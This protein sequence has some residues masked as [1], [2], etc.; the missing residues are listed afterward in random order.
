MTVTDS[1]AS[2]TIIPTSFTATQTYDIWGGS[3]A[4]IIKRDWTVTPSYCPSLT[5]YL[6]VAGTTTNANQIFSVS[7]AF[8]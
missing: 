2:A 8:Y 3:P 6:Y 7:D 4:N 1:C 5:Y